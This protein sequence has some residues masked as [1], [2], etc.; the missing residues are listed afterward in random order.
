MVSSLEVVHFIAAWKDDNG[1]GCVIRCNVTVMVLYV[2]ILV[3]DRRNGCHEKPARPG[4]RMVGIGALSR[5]QSAQKLIKYR[6]LMK[7]ASPVQS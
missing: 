4:K 2:I 1:V 6:L 7:F 5:A 3:L